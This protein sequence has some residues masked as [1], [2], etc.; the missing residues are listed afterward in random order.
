MAGLHHPHVVA[1]YGVTV[2]SNAV[3][4]AAETPC[5]VMELCAGGSY[6]DV[7]HPKDGQA[8]STMAQKVRV[9]RESALGMIYLHS[10][11]PPIIHRD[12][13]AG[14][15]LLTEG[16]QAKVSALPCPHPFR[17][18]PHSLQLPPPT[19]PTPPSNSP[20]PPSP[21]TGHRFRHIQS[22]DGDPNGSDIGWCRWYSAV[23]GARAAGREQIR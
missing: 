23:H 14:N 11:K 1:F 4:A 9:L 16:G 22:T 19:P 7:L 17:A 12:M 5:V 15:I 18:P 13:K 20:L 6:W 10:R 21:A 8:P 2:D 3:G